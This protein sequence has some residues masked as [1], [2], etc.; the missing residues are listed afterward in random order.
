MLAA[1]ENFNRRRDIPDGCPPGMYCSDAVILRK[2]GRCWPGIG[3][4]ESYFQQQEEKRPPRSI[5]FPKL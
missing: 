5:A 4:P 1:P 3:Q 2:E